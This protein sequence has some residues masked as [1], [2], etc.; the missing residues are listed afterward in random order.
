MQMS[1]DLCILVFD[2]CFASMSSC[3]LCEYYVT[4]FVYIN[5][6]LYVLV[7]IFYLLCL[8]AIT[9]VYTAFLPLPGV[10][11][12]C[13]LPLYLCTVCQQDE[14]VNIPCL[15]IFCRDAMKFFQ[16]SLQ[17]L[18]FISTSCTM[19]GKKSKHLYIVQT[20]VCLMPVYMQ[21]LYINDIVDMA[22]NTTS[23]QLQISS[24]VQFFNYDALQ[25]SVLKY[26]LKVCFICSFSFGLMI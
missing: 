6:M 11:T 20:P 24:L 12:R 19:I 22:S 17:L 16:Y 3:P 9:C 13:S 15:C 10:S 18:P 5:Q 14:Q 1:P 2:G 21:Y 25:M 23:L 26:I 7:V 8:C 4:S